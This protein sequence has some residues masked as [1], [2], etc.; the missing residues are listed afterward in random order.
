MSKPK[1]YEIVKID[2]HNQLVTIINANQIAYIEYNN[3]NSLK[4][5]FKNNIPLVFNGKIA[6]Q[7]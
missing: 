4:L 6:N 1:F 5:Y 2:K 3:V 7:I